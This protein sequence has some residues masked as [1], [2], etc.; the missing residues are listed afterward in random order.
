MEGVPCWAIKILELCCCF[1][2]CWLIDWLICSVWIQFSNLWNVS[3]GSVTK[4]GRIF[5]TL[6]LQDPGPQ[7]SVFWGQSP[8]LIVALQ[9]PCYNFPL[10]SSP[11]SFPWYSQHL[12]LHSLFPPLQHSPSSPSISLSGKG[13]TLLF[14]PSL[15]LTCGWSGG[16]Q[17]GNRQ[18]HL[19]G[20][21]RTQQRDSSEHF[22]GFCFPGIS[23]KR[24]KR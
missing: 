14:V 4:G 2:T 11:L 15:L 21:L 16:G 10:N 18:P 23:E 19:I 6:P 1:P 24:N 13:E 17:G 5:L 22:N 8:D 12:I 20:H 7:S 9:P 3:L